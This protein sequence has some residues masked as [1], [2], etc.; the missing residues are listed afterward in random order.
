MYR[1]ETFREVGGFDE[2]FFCYFEDVDFGFRL[3]LAGYRALS[4]STAIVYHVGSATSGGQNSDFAVYHGQRNLVWTFV[5]NMPGIVLWILLP[6][7]C[8]LNVLTLFLFSFR[9]QSHIILKAKIDAIK[10]LPKAIA[11][12]KLIQRHRKCSIVNILKFMNKE[13]FP[14]RKPSG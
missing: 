5:K 7:H 4:V 12:R 13:L 8:G 2:D 11:K 14:L 1:T 6:L 3:R 9:G 10:D